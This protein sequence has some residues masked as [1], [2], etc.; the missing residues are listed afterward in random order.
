LDVGVE[1]R[2]VSAVPGQQSRDSVAELD[3]HIAAVRDGHEHES[4]AN[5]QTAECDAAHDPPRHD[6]PD[7]DPKA[8]LHVD[9]ATPE[10]PCRQQ[11]EYV[12]VARFGVLGLLCSQGQHRARAGAEQY[13]CRHDV[14]PLRQSLSADRSACGIDSDLFGAVVPHIDRSRAR[15]R[16]DEPRR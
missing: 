6:D 14:E 9:A 3:G 5:D 12:V 11:D 15:H 16:Q 8:D 4:F 10:R 2:Q 7:V 1:A 13:A